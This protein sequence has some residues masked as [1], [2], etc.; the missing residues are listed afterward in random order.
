[1]KG[2]EIWTMDEIEKI[3]ENLVKEKPR[4]LKW[5]ILKA[6]TTG[7]I[8]DRKVRMCI[9]YLLEKGKILENQDKYVIN[10]K[11]VEKKK[12]GRPCKLCEKFNNENRTIK[13][14]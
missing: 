7:G 9:K 3:I 5:E 13:T 4:I 8:A 11:Y 6:C 12:E 2:N 1:M 10:S 14:I